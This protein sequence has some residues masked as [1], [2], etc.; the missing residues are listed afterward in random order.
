MNYAI[1][2]LR[3]G[4]DSNW[5]AKDSYNRYLCRSG[6]SGPGDVNDPDLPNSIQQVKIT[7]GLPGTG[8]S[9]TR[10]ISSK[11]TYTYTP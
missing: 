11:A 1:E 4:T 8:I 7:V 5:P 2:I 9:G 10:P 6:C 3:V